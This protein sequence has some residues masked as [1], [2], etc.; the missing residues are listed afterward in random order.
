MKVVYHLEQLNQPISLEK[1]IG[2]S[3][4]RVQVLKETAKVAAI[5]DEA[6][7]PRSIQETME[8]AYIERVHELLL[9]GITVFRWDKEIRKV[10]VAT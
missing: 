1:Y 10:Y 8:Q 9:L 6:T 2:S 3:L 5:A 4:S 7:F